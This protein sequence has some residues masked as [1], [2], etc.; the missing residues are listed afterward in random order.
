MTSYEFALRLNR[1][2]ADDELDALYEAG[3]GDA[4]IETG[5]LGAVADFDREAPSLAHAIASAV[6]DIEKVPGL[7]AIGVRCDN[8]LNLLG[9]AQRAGVTREA[10]RLWA[11]GRR[12]PGS[13]P[14]PTLI[15]AGGEQLWD[16]TAVAP[17]VERHQADSTHALGTD[18]TAIVT[19]RIFCTADRV[20][21][22]RDALMSEPD[23]DVRQEFERLLEDA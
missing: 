4:G 10:A 6:R 12:G 19:L 7:R 13:F 20:L 23:E 22:A 2:V 17:W 15:S 8:M 9:I 1:E 5:P 11:T 16:W 18:T 14:K 21:A 3:C